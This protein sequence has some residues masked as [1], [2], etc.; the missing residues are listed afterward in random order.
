VFLI[1]FSRQIPRQTSVLQNRNAKDEKEKGGKRKNEK[2]KSKR[3][4]AMAMLNS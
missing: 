4:I 1:L 3:R 2:R